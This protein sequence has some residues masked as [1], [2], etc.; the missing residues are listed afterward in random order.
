VTSIGGIS[1]DPHGFGIG[2]YFDP[3]QV[4][5]RIAGALAPRSAA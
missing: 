4:R 3:E 1:T 5:A 2:T